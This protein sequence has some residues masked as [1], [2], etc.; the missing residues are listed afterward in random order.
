VAIVTNTFQTYQAKGIREELSNLISNISPEE[1]VFMSNIEKA[2]CSNTYFEWQQDALAAAATNAQ[3]E[4]DDLTS[5]TAVVPTSRIG[6]Y[7]QISRKDVII[8]GTEDSAVDKAGRKSE[9]A[10]Q[11]VKKGKELKLDMELMLCDNVAAAAG[12]TGTARRTAGLGAWV[13]TNVSL[14]VGGAN[15]SAPAPAPAGIRTDGTQRTFTE[16]MLKD[17]A[18][19]GWTNGARFDTI[20]VG[21]FN[22]GIISGFT[23]IATKTFYQSAPKKASII[24]AADV[25]VGEFQTFTVV[26]NRLQRARDA[27]FLDH[28]FCKLRT[29]RPFNTI[30]LAKTGDAE[31]RMILVEYGLEVTNEKGLG[32]VADL[33]TV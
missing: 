5:F 2:S 3:I 10:Y 8:A 22:K 24:G 21:A 27:W 26:P 20:M 9:L 16:L 19:Q 7:T 29:L 4:G 28:N 14:G 1:T 12:A 6:N 30:E 23:G 31:K 33:T 17:V 18:A 15:P 13:R 25:Y 32:L 11:I